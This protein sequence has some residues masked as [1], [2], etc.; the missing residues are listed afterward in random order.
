MSSEDNKV[1]SVCIVYNDNTLELI[2]QEGKYTFAMPEDDVEIIVSY[3]PLYKLSV[4]S[5]HGQVTVIGD[6]IN[7]V[8]EEE[9]VFTVEPDS[10]Y[11]LLEVKING[12]IVQPQFGEYTFN[13]PAKNV[14]IEVTYAELFDI[15]VTNEHGKV[16]ITDGKTQAIAGENV[17]FTV[18]PNETYRI[19]EVKVNDNILTA[20]DGKYIFEMPASD[21]TIIVSYIQGYNVQVD[22][23]ARDYITIN[24]DFVLDSA[25]VT[26]TTD[27]LDSVTATHV[28]QRTVQILNNE[29]K[30][31]DYTQEGNQYSFT[32]PAQDVTI[33]IESRTLERITDFAISSTVITDYTGDAEEVTVPS[34]YYPYVQEIGNTFTFNSLTEFMNAAMSDA[35]LMFALFNMKS[36]KTADSTEPVLFNDGQE[37]LDFLEN[38]TPS[39]TEKQFPLEITLAT[40]VDTITQEVVD[41]IEGGDTREFYVI[42]PFIAMHFSNNYILSFTYQIGDQDPVEVDKEMASEF[43]VKNFDNNAFDYKSL[44]PIKFSNIKYGKI[45]ACKG[46]GINIKSISFHADI[47]DDSVF[48]D[49]PTVKKITISE[50][51]TSL[52]YDSIQN[53]E[54]LKELI[55]PSTLETIFRQN[56]YGVFSG[57]PKLQPYQCENGYYLGNPTNNCVVLIDVIDKNASSFAVS[58]GCKIISYDFSD[59]NNMSQITIPKS[60]SSMLLPKCSSVYYA[61]T[62]DQWLGIV[63]D[64]YSGS[65]GFK[66]YVNGDE[67]VTE[68]TINKN[69]PDYAFY[70]IGSLT[71]VTLGEGVTTIGNNAFFNCSS[72]TDIYYE[73]TLDQW[74]DINFD[75]SWTPYNTNLNLYFNDEL[76]DD[77]TINKNIPDY[78]FSGI[79]S[80][81][82]VTI[83]EGVTQI[84]YSA[85]QYC[86][87]L[88]SIT[89]PSSLISI[90]DWAF[91]GCSNLQY[92]NY[93]NGK[94]LGNDENPYLV[95]IDVD[96]T[97]VQ[98]FE[99]HKDCKIIYP[100]VFQSCWD[101]TSVTIPEGVTS[102][103]DYAFS[104]GSNLLEIR[105]EGT[106]D[107]W[108]NIDFGSYWS[109]N[110]NDVVNLYINDNLVTEVTINKD[111]PDHA[112]Y[113][114]DSLTKVTLGEGVT[115]IGAWAFDGCTSLTSITI[116]E[117]VTSIGEYAF[118]VCTNLTT[119]VIE[120]DDIYKIA[121]SASSAGSLLEYATTVKVLKTIDDGSSIYLSLMG[122]FT[123][124]ESDPTYNVYTKL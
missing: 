42:A 101:L 61:G 2:A 36:Y 43:V 30:K 10:N 108:L 88:T 34:S 72:L 92:N 29:G 120:S 124:D 62:L 64:S 31:I 6:K 97:S 25:T 67:L 82:K 84:G 74:L 63:D 102:F 75:S 1:N 39:L 50:G 69:I 79:G 54:N 90:G 26:F 23:N 87:N 115:S 3:S 103:S 44:L 45:I 76:A 68:V 114:I 100:Y 28:I 98:S 60:V 56:N 91:S 89:L 5:E 15:S 96:N 109:T 4:I 93:N 40:E 58:E 35:G 86:S 77:I 14:T 116:P 73:G 55:L 107:Q 66:L 51:I 17:E 71:K 46:S 8:E 12:E 99:I 104:S 27:E 122:G 105:Y 32:M 22:E 24:D 18:A 117:G 80:L 38:T 78:A 21:V 94:Y 85:F 53:C 59:C 118:S 9:V 123:L 41:K 81:T 70:N 119:V 111:I 106:L 16:E 20:Q 37:V 7:A 113:S 48:V 65:S 57:C 110:S 11:R 49:N 112:F 47:V 33:S 83:G 121:T 52:G 13:M 95:L 19:D